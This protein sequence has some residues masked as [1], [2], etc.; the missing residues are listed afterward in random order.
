SRGD[1][2]GSYLMKS[3]RTPL[4]R[5]LMGAACAVVAFS[6]PAAAEDLVIGLDSESTSID[7][8]Y[9]NL[10]PNNQLGFM[11]FDR[12]ANPDARQNFKPGLAVSWQPVDSTTWEFKLREGVKFHDGSDFNADDVICT[13]ERAPNV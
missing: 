5:A 13:F 1:P 10:G 11:M 3:A 9:H 7:P 8:H 4:A 12:L 2:E 6:A